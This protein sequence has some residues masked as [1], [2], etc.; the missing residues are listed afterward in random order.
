[1]G[2]DPLERRAH[3]VSARAWPVI[4][5]VIALAASVACSRPPAPEGD[6]ASLVHAAVL[7]YEAK[8]FLSEEPL[9]TC[10]AIQGSPE[11][12]DTRV[13]ETLHPTLPGIRS[14]EACTVV[15]GDVY[16]AGSRVPAALLTSGPI[17]WIA[18]DEAEVTG[19]FTRT[20]SS[21]R[22]PL[23]RVVHDGGRW[24][25]LGPVVTGMPL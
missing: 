4:G 22:R 20:R 9:P 7:R 15:D 19:G 6:A 17:R 3:A 24:V 2:G 16:L 25:C 12:M 13:R 10:V 11:G 21:S 5:A 8:Q 1:V 18:D 23:Y 14:A